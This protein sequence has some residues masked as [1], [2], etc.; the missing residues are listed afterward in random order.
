MCVKP[1]GNKNLY[2]PNVTLNGAP[3]KLVHKEKYLGF[4]FSDDCYNNDHITHEMRN[5]FARG[6]MLIR[7]FKHCSDVV[8]VKLYQT[9]CSSI[10]CCG[11]ISVYHKQVIKK[12]HVAFNKILKCLLNVPS[13]SSASALFVSMN[14]DNF[15]VLR[16]KL[17]YSLSRRTCSSSNS[18]IVDIFNS[19]HFMN[20]QLKKEWDN[21][22]YT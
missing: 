3:I 18:F 6:S 19:E 17:V 9:Y 14:V 22:L 2:V 10:Y 12:L 7:N 5:T 11:L 13:R 1:G 21:V 20:C 4:I 8:K 15:L 16:R